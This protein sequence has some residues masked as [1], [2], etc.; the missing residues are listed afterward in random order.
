MHEK[1]LAA[2]VLRVEHN[3]IRRKRTMEPIVTSET[4]LVEDRADDGLLHAWR[5][6]QLRHLGF[7]RAFA[8]TFAGIVD[9]HEIAD[10][11]ASG[12]PPELALEIV[13]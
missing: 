7:P 2:I 10:L 5:A 8:E 4:E 3:S 6:E 13:R 11:I 9:W 1:L 12:C